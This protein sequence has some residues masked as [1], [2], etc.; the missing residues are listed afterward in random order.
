M[1]TNCCSEANDSRNMKFESAPESGRRMRI[2][3][4][5]D[6]PLDEAYYKELVANTWKDYE[7][8]EMGNLEFDE[9]CKFLKVVMKVVTLEEATD[10][11]AEKNFHIIDIDKDGSID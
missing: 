11:E 3:P 2:I 4:D 5:M 10:A 1:G 7:T 6:K 8:N 9:A